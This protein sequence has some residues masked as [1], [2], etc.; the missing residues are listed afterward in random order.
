MLGRLFGLA[1]KS[2]RPDP[3]SGSSG[4][5]PEQAFDLSSLKL[6]MAR[7]PPSYGHTLKDA[8]KALEKMPD[9]KS[10]SVASTW[11]KDMKS[12]SEKLA[13]AECQM[14]WDGADDPGN[15]LNFSPAKKALVEILVH[16][17][18]LSVYLGPSIF[19]P[20]IPGMIKEFHTS[21]TVAT[22]GTS[23]S[24]LGYGIGPMIWSP[25]SECPS[26][27]RIPVY[28][29]TLALFVLIQLPIALAT[30]VETV[31]ILRFFSGVFGSPVLAI[32]GGSLTDV[33]LPRRRSYSVAAWELST[34]VAPTIG[35]LVGG[36]VA[37]EWGWR[38]TLWE[39]M[40]SNLAV[41]VVI[42]CLMPE[43][44]AS[45]ILYRRAKKL[46]SSP[47]VSLSKQ[48]PPVPT[49]D[50]PRRY[51][52]AL[53]FMHQT[54]I[55]PFS[56]C[57]REPICLLLNTY[58]ALSTG[59]FFAWFETLPFV[60]S[61]IYN[62]DLI[63]IGLASLGLLG[64]AATSYVAYITYFRWSSRKNLGPP[65]P[66]DRFVPLMAG[67][68]FMPLGL[69]VFGWT[70]RKEIPCIMSILNYLPDAYPSFAASVLAGNNFVRSVF[71]AACVL[72]AAP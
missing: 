49:P 14:E 37:Q 23:I 60:F 70:A 16:L 45:N 6:E 42:F 56:L 58:T 48:S 59:L 24:L 3:E 47:D 19:S 64:G 51:Q 39:L 43:T 50:P 69:F 71:A 18:T 10:L 62:F 67:C 53:A 28:T 12:N 36:L 11:S 7:I 61:T 33:Y 41:F 31:I 38:W 26:I 5:L 35:P 27:G 13:D 72:F 9:Q 17:L 40:L 4:W 25:L 63:H 52:A 1:S 34:W 8:I 54:L 20:S 21:E 30:N 55:R 66:E 32:G 46:H 15:P 57:F 68:A 2:T 65:R 29:A 44:S 22:M